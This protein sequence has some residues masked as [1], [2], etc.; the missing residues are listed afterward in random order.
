MLTITLHEAV[1]TERWRTTINSW[2]FFQST[3]AYFMFTY[4]KYPNN[5]LLNIQNILVLLFIRWGCRDHDRMVVG[6]TTHCAI[7]AYHY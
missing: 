2:F 7:S 1:V 3:P 6:F 4:N 5:F